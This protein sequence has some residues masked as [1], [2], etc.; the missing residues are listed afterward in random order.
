MPKYVA[1]GGK[2]ECWENIIKNKSFPNPEIV[3]I[4]EVEKENTFILEY[5]LHQNVMSLKKKW[6]TVICTKM[7]KPRWINL[8]VNQKEK[9]KYQMIS[10]ICGN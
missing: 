4:K 6:N 8:E 3:S 5:I 2:S 9:N 10:L 7:D 1:G